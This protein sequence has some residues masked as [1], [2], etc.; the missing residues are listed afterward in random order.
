MKKE[1]IERIFST[2]GQKLMFDMEIEENELVNISHNLAKAW[3][4]DSLDIPA[5]LK[6]KLLTVLLEEI[7]T[8]SK[9]ITIK[10]NE[11][12]NRLNKLTA[13]KAKGVKSITK[14]NN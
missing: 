2:D 7:K 6:R 12:L 8:Y 3:Y 13:G 1:E 9:A 4:I 10:I 11:S 14:K 5:G